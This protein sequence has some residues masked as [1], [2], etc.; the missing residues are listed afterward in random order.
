M[1]PA[2][3]G[4]DTRGT[5]GGIQKVSSGSPFEATIGFSRAVC[6][7][8]RV[9]VSGTGPVW[10]TAAAT[11]T[12]PSRRRCFEIVADALAEAGAIA[13]VRAGE[14]HARGGLVI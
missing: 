11:P 14:Q 5:G 1:A 13:R 9:L 6:V 4:G 7:V 2:D 8:A 3:P 10:L 12:P